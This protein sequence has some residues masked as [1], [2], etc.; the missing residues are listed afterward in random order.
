MLKPIGQWNLDMGENKCRIARVF[1][2]E[3]QKAAF[4]LEQWSPSEEADWAVA[5]REVA[6]FRSD[7]KTTYAFGP[8]GKSDDF[9]F[10][11]TSFGD[12]GNLVGARSK[13]VSD[14]PSQE[15]VNS[16]DDDERDWQARPRGLEQLDSD[17]AAQITSL[18]LS[19]SG[20]TDVVIETGGLKP[21][22]AAMNACMEDLVRHWG[23]DPAEQRRVVSPPKATN[24]PKVVQYIMSTYPAGALRKGAQAT[25]HLRIMVGTNGAVEECVLTNQTLAEDFDM[26]RHPCFAFT[27]RAVMEPARDAAGEPVRSFYTARIAYRIG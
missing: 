22:L 13:I 21:V 15:D 18:T 4:Y 12:F 11:K 16:N 6:G 20:R 3:E 8:G 17:R 23:L 7:R 10:T 14:D 24:M 26:K 9:E 19:Q 27:T 5:A 25:F 2:S 1:G